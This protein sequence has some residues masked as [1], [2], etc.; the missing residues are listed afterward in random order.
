M[1]MRYRGK[2]FE[3]ALAKNLSDATGAPLSRDSVMDAAQKHY[4]GHATPD[5]D[6]AASEAIL[7]LC[8]ND[9]Q[10]D[11]ALSIHVLP[12]ATGAGGDVRDVVAKHLDG[13]VG[14][15]AKNRHQA[16]KHSRLSGT[17]DFA[18]NWTGYSVSDKYWAAVRPVFQQLA[19]LRDEGKY[20]RDMRDKERAIYLPVLEA[21][22]DEFNRLCLSHGRPFIRRVFQY[23]V[24][25][26]DYYKVV[27]QT[28][29]VFVQSYNINGTL[30]W[31]SR[32]NIPDEIA[33]IG[34][35]RGSLNTLEV[36]F[37]DGW[38]MTFRIHNARALVEPSLKFDIQFQAMPVS[39]VS[40]QIRLNLRS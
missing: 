22:E 19:E 32:W 5:M 20:F 3:F 23:L 40:N 6:E 9:S 24:G 11:D 8:A 14:L 38:Q 28:D 2:A 27:N 35:R 30:E 17:L 15:S 31:G 36:S 16:I 10:F 37:R 1:T 29:H 34:R 13:E 26:H 33:R 4:D 12:D 18:K 21:F 39:V 25:R 7:F